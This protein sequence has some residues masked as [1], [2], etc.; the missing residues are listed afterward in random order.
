M[1][2]ATAIPRLGQRREPL[3]MLAGIGA[4]QAVSVLVFAVRGKLAA[5]ALGPEG[6]GILGVLEPLIQTLAHVFAFG[7]PIAAV[8]FLSRAHSDGLAAFDS[9]YARFLRRLLLST[10][11]GTA[12]AVLLVWR[13]PSIVGAA[14]APYRSLIV[15]S[16]LGAPLLALRDLLTNA[17][18]AV[19]AT[20]AS[21]GLAPILAIGSTVGALAGLAIGRTTTGFVAGTLAGTAVVLI[22]AARRLTRVARTSATE[23]AATPTPEASFDVAETALVLWACFASHPLAQFAARHIVLSRFGS[24]EAG[25]LQAASSLS[26]ALGLLLGPA[27]ALYLA[28]LM[29]RRGPIATKGP[30]AMS[31]LREQALAAALLGLPLILFPQMILTVLFAPAFAHASGALALLVVGQVL[32]VLSGVFYVLLVS[33]DDVRAYGA[34]VVLEQIGFVW[35]SG[36]LAA[37]TGSWN[38]ALAFLLAN[39]A[40]LTLSALRVAWRHGIVPGPAVTAFVACSVAASLAVGMASALHPCVDP[41]DIVLRLIVGVLFAAAFGLWARRPIATV[42]AS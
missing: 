28:P 29:N 18:A 1:S 25:L 32:R 9:A 22:A 4:L 3:A 35:L 36:A 2:E 6:V 10:L 8:K 34:I 7:L 37:G 11:F 41:A 21:A 30:I 23:S 27:T 16:L 15:L 39:L 24:A 38:V 40:L 12:A 26:G 20:K 13:W 14:L 5:V 19:R 17:L 42:E 31:F 33:L